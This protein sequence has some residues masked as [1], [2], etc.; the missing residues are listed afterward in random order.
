M[1]ILRDHYKENFRRIFRIEFFVLILLTLRFI[2]PEIEC[3][4]T[5]TKHY[6]YFR[7]SQAPIKFYIYNFSLPEQAAL[8][9]NNY[10]DQNANSNVKHTWI[11]EYLI[12][13]HL[14]KQKTTVNDPEEADL[15]YVP[16]YFGAYNANNGVYAKKVQMMNVYSEIMNHGP[17]LS[18]SGGVDHVF[19]QIYMQHDRRLQETLKN[20]P[21]MVSVGDIS[22]DYSVNSPREAWRLTQVPYS[23]NYEDYTNETRRVVSLF[24]IGQQSLDKGEMKSRILRKELAQNLTRMKNTIAI[25]TKDKKNEKPATSFNIYNFMKKS[26]FCPVPSGETPSSKR[27][28]DAFKSRCIP[29]ILSDELRFP[30]EEVFCDYSG[31][32]LQV[33]MSEVGSLPSI[34]GMIPDKGKRKIRQ[35]INEMSPLLNLDPNAD[36]HHGDLIW[37]WKWMHFF[38]AATVATSKRRTFM[39]NKYYKPKYQLDS[40]QP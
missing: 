39:Q 14:L 34:V 26:Q 2:F 33:P 27:L 1:Y 10:C 16:I 3:K 5:Y 20:I 12:H 19:T 17:Y 31:T 37:A 36:S 13:R 7:N 28:Y 22:Y 9:F 25:F 30:F 32:I 21:S 23:S 11:F 35:R 6:F 8:C 24:F 15:F 18:R 29:I 4:S 38:K 40:S